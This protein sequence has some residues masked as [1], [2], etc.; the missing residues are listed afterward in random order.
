MTAF[1]RS[2]SVWAIF[3]SGAWELG[4]V[5]GSSLFI[6]GQQVVGSR[7]GAIAATSG[8]STIDVEARTVI[9]QILVALRQ[10]GLIET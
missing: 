4:M 10:H 7:T 2:S 5:R 9:A 3:R 6:G 1:V 8:G